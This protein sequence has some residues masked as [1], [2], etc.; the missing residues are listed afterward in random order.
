M[1]KVLKNGKYKYEITEFVTHK[2]HFT[3]DKPLFSHKYFTVDG[4]MLFI[5]PGYQWDGASGPAVNTSNFIISS[6]VHDVLY[7]AI[8]EGIIDKK[9]KK[10]ADKELYLLCREYGMNLFRA[11]YVYIAVKLFGK[12]HI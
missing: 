6:L 4:F 5:K 1:F 3:I 9:Y 2:L 7:Q 12:F 11:Q 8:R 10:D